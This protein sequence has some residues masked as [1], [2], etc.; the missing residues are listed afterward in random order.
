MIEDQIC[1]GDLVVIEGRREAR[2][3]E[4]VVALVDGTDATLKRFY[5]S[6]AQVKL[7]PANE[8]MLPMEFHASQ[9][10]IRGVVRGLIRHF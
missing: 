10:E 7:V 1:D 8:T 9:V 4:T 5:R 2:N 6:G 3:G